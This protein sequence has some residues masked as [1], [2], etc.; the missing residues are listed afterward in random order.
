MRM[1]TARIKPVAD[2]ELDAKQS[3]LVNAFAPEVRNLGLFRTMLRSVG[4]TKA[5]LA[6]AN[7]IQSKNDLSPRQKEIVVLRT[8]WLTR[9]GY[10]WSHHV[11]FG[12][13]AGL[14]PAEIAA[15]KDKGENAWPRK[16]AA[17]IAACDQ[18]VRDHCIGRD[19]WAA[20]ASTLSEKQMMDLVFT[21]GQYTL[22]AMATNSFGI[23]LD[24]IGEADAD[25]AKWDA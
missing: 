2:S 11:R 12:R 20:L 21:V 9:S 19:T 24:A 7:Y 13:A 1:H 5:L 18:L 22:V 4:A 6:W 15:L 3:E 17:L 10:E 14:N 23:Q 8:S 16:E 25:L